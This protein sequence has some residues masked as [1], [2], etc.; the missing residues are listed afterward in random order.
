MGAIIERLNEMECGINCSCK[1]HI[2]E[3]NRRYDMLSRETSKLITNNSKKFSLNNLNKLIE[4]RPDKGLAIY[5][6]SKKFEEVSVRFSNLKLFIFRNGIVY[7]DCSLVNEMEE[8]K[9]TVVECV[10]FINEITSSDA[11]IV[12]SKTSLYEELTLSLASTED[13]VVQIERQFNNVLAMDVCKRHILI[14]CERS[15][16]VVRGELLTLRSTI[17]EVKDVVT[18][19]LEL[20]SLI[21]SAK[22]VLSKLTHLN[23]VIYKVIK[24]VK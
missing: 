22:K 3:I 15:F 18:P 21:H 6:C 1:K 20:C 17:S 5:K 19:N 14:D 24:E 11:Q 4:S 9:S 16:L 12:E 8:V 2:D 13:E 7:K 10:D 23:E